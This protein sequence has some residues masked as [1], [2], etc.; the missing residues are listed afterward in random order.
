[1]ARFTRSAEV[2]ERRAR[3]LQLRIEHHSYAEIGRQLRISPKLAEL[4]YRRALADLKHEQDEHA[5]TARNIEVG[6]LGAIEHAAW[7]VLRRKHITVQ[8]GHI[9]RTDTGEP[10]EDNAPVLQAID[11]IL[12]ISERRARLL[13]MDAPQRIEVDDARRAEI[14]RLAAELA[15]AGVGDLEPGGTGTPPRRT[16]EGEVSTPAP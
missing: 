16:P 7:E 15:A 11:R 6:R 10:V 14:K 13:G 9:V 12:R 3:V 4:D 2:A 5:A 1:M 8:H